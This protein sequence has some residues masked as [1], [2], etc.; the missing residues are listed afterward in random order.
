MGSCFLFLMSQRDRK[1]N[2]F[3]NKSRPKIWLQGG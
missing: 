3:H 1:W 2:S